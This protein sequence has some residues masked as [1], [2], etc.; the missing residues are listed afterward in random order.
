[1]TRPTR[2]CERVVSHRRLRRL[3][4]LG[5]Y[6]SLIVFIA[7][8]YDD[9]GV[10]WDEEFYVE[11]GEAYVAHF[12]DMKAFAEGVDSLHLETHG[13]LFDGL[14]FLALRTLGR[15][16]DYETLHLLKA[17][18][19]SLVVVLV[20]L[21]LC[22][23]QPDSL[24]PVAGMLLLVA[25]P[26]W[27][28]QIFDDHMDGAAT[29]LYA[30]QMAYALPLLVFADVSAA[31]WARPLAWVAGFGVLAGASFSHRV[32]LAAVPVCVF[33]LWFLQAA[34][35]RG[36]VRFGVLAAVFAATLYATVFVV[37][38][39]VR[40]EWETGLLRK[41]FYAANP[42]VSSLL[43]VLFEGVV[44]PARELPLSYLATW[45]GMS[46]PLLTL[47]LVVVG[48]ARLSSWLVRP[49]D[50]RQRLEAAFVLLTLALPLGAALVTRAIVFDG[51]RHLLF[52]AVPL[53]VVASL[54]LGW[55]GEL[56]P[57]R[58]SR[59]GVLVLLLALAPI[60]LSMARLH[61]YEYLYVNEAAGGLKAT[62]GRY[63]ND[64]WAKSYKAAAEWVR[65]RASREPNR[66]RAVYVCGPDHPAAYYFSE[67]MTLTDDVDRADYLICF[68]RP[69]WS[70]AAPPRPPD[71]TIERE[72]VVL[73]R[74]WEL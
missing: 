12:F 56:V 53:V 39:Y 46:I 68:T 48:I 32:P 55:L 50:L 1:M 18:A 38:P 5:V 8:T 58:M 4:A 69:G 20:Y 3:L 13:A 14:Y 9:Y 2:E 71:H 30:L 43:L 28:G 64:Y 65:E 17:L 51:W 33:L 37:D 21:M 54:G 73:A 66:S 36:R 74:I 52:L 67:N 27:L 47:A 10:S 60:A 6:V 31:G 29:L 11:T 49:V 44:R 62:A 59:A 45:M 63:E 24:V 26:A 61:P 22:R 35:A 40:V 57:A 34:D 70:R 15:V 7:A 19:S 41:V 16:G 23:L 25:L 42:R 72:G